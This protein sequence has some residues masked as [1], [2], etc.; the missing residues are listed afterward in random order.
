MT[1]V[2]SSR[3]PGTLGTVL[4]AVAVLATAAAC[5]TPDE[6][7]LDLTSAE[8]AIE[9]PAEIIDV[10]PS[11]HIGLELVQ[12]YGA[13]DSGD[14]PLYRPTAIDVDE[15][16]NV[17]V[18]D[19]GNKKIVV[20]SADGELVRTM[21]REGQGPGEFQQPRGLAVVNGTTFA[22]VDRARMGAWDSNGELLSDQ[23]LPKSYP[24]QDLYA[25]DSGTLITSYPISPNSP[26]EVVDSYVPQVIVGYDATASLVREYATTPRLF[27]LAG[28]TTPG[29]HPTSIYGVDRAGRIYVSAGATYDVIAI[30]ADGH[31]PWH[32][33]VDV[34]P[35]RW[36]EDDT[37]M[38]LAS[39]R[40]P[41]GRSDYIWPEFLPALQALK[42]DG[43]GHLYVYRY[44]RRDPDMT[45]RLADVFDRDGRH[46]FSGTLDAVP[47]R[48]ARSDLVYAIVED[49]ASGG[50]MVAA[51][52]IVEPFK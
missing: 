38:V 49:E 8:R 21:G 42:V 20:F 47:W 31:R 19:G 14:G 52:R 16:G 27:R 28:V 39:S 32:L 15:E 10:N 6:I 7:V 1:R 45:R 46:L 37:D 2:C 5:G 18:L 3:I 40:V 36:T 24:H 25:L 22:L 33:G 41:I 43:H 30:D 12:L 51:Y 50:N 26:G 48:T 4:A 13:S 29:P 34:E 23:R 9:Y 11:A 17:Y 35:Q 44:M